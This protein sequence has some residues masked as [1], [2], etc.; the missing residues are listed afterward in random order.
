MSITSKPVVFGHGVTIAKRA[1]DAQ[2]YTIAIY[3]T[4]ENTARIGVAMCGKH[5]LFVKK[6]GR[7][8]AEGRARKRCTFVVTGEDIDTKT[9]EG[10]LRVKGAA[11]EY[12]EHMANH[13][14]H[15]LD[16]LKSVDLVSYEPIVLH[17]SKQEPAASDK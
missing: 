8:I 14:K 9:V 1:A 12:V 15:M 6:I 5:E 13:V 2:R 10:I 16:D 11:K 17:L 4:D 7:D 3:P